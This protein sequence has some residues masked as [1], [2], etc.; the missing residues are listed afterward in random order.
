MVQVAFLQVA[1][2]FGC[3]QSLL[4]MNLGLIN[5]LSELDVKYFNKENFSDI[6]D[7]DITYGII[8][9][10]ARTKQETANIKLF[11]KKCQ[12]II[13][14]GACAC[15]GGIKSLANLYDKSELIDSIKN[16][17]DYTPDLEDFIVN[18]KDIIDVDMFIPGCPPTTN[19]IAA[20]LLYLILLSK[21]LPAT[22]NK[23]ETV[24]NSCN[25]FNNGCF[26]G[27]N[28]LCY[29]PITAAGCTLMCPNDGDVCFGCF[30]ATNS[31]GEKTKV[32]EELIYNMLSLSSKDAASLQHF[33]D[34]YI[35]VANIGN[36]YNR[37][38]LLQRLAF[39]PTSLKLKEIEVGNQKVKTFE[40]N[41]TDIV[42][43]NEII[44][45]IIYLLQG[46]P[47]FKYSSKSV[48]SHC[49]RVIVDKIPISLKRDYEGLP[50][51]DKCF[52]EQGYLC[53]GLVTKAGCG[54]MCPNRANAP[55]LG[56]YGPTIGVKEQGAKFIS[57]LGSLTSEIDPEEVV[58]F[59]KDPA[60]S[61]NRF[62]LANTT[63]GRKFH[64]LK[65]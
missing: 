10:V 61:F 51:T 50:A 57:T 58:D 12:S 11:R 1:S 41:P 34:L 8:E 15:Y 53:M 20:S 6:K 13:A 22:V 3:H 23:K 65:E 37:N 55:C 44:G 4:N 16:S 49:A 27:K 14:L 64:D 43:I 26:L 39:E 31:L 40:V 36:F 29:G 60:G 59:I 47:N 25:L 33:I 17:I 42:K 48:C 7:G 63:L 54:T 21:E 46:D 24:C 30:K 62:S 38:D 56:C 32:L 2:C 5:V 9:G 52:L 45:R 18:I 35:G 19:N 28:K